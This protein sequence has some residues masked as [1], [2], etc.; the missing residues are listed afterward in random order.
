MGKWFEDCFLKSQIDRL[1]KQ[2]YKVESGKVKKYNG[3][4]NSVILT[5][6]QAE[7]CYRNMSYKQCHGDY[8]YF[9]VYT[10]DT[11]NH[12]FVMRTAGKYTFLEIYAK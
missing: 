10:Y 6:K 2:R 9:S 5:E 3:W 11:S 8:G 12:S 7:V 4:H 1:N